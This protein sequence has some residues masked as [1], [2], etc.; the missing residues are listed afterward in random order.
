MAP[1]KED[2][3]AMDFYDLVD[4]WIRDTA[5]GSYYRREIMER[6]MKQGTST[7]RELIDPS[8]LAPRVNQLPL[9]V[10]R[11]DDEHL[12]VL[13]RANLLHAEN[14]TEACKLMLDSE[15]SFSGD[16]WMKKT[17]EE[18]RN[19]LQ[20]IIWDSRTWDELSAPQQN[21]FLTIRDSY[22]RWYKGRSVA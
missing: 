5:H 18:A 17:P 22:R 1:H 11:Q 9:R 7:T 4:H 19:F 6:L 2:L 12:A 15:W 16:H 20:D 13:S 10:V 14:L 3:Q 21:L 8:S